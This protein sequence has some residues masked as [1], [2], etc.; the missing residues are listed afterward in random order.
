VLAL[1][2]I[3]RI[4]QNNPTFIVSSLNIHR[5]LIT[6]LSNENNIISTLIFVIIFFSKV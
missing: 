5:L 6:G 4:I 2:Y 3:D 1:V